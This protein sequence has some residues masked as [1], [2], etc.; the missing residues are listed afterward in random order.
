MLRRAYGSISTSSKSGDSQRDPFEEPLEKDDCV[1]PSS[2]DSS[3][4]EEEEEPSPSQYQ[5]E[6]VRA[7]GADEIEEEEQL[8]MVSE[9]EDDE[10]PTN[11]STNHSHSR[12]AAADQIYSK[13]P[14]M[15]RNFIAQMEDARKRELMHRKTCRKSLDFADMPGPRRN[16][17][18]FTPPRK[19][20]EI[21]P[22]TQDEYDIERDSVSSRS[23]RKRLQP[24]FK[25]VGTKQLRV[26]DCTGAQVQEWIEQTA[27]ADMLKA[28]NLEDVTSKRESIGGFLR[29]HVSCVPL[30]VCG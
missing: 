9:S 10:D 18:A 25:V 23:T 14:N 26:A 16:Q 1:V 5:V 19:S 20:R 6:R 8:D 4:E 27:K 17:M 7:D 12:P 30:F 3:E 24:K 22:A 29:A 28:G 2:R 11:D 15:S 21:I 13:F